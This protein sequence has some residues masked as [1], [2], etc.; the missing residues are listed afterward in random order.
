MTNKKVILG[1]AIFIIAGL[2]IFTF[3]NSLN[4]NGSDNDGNLYNPGTSDNNNTDDDNNEMNNDKDNTSDEDGDKKD[5]DKDDKDS[6]DED[7]ST[8][9]SGTNNGSTS[10][11]GSNQS[12]GSNSGSN[13]NQGGSNSGSNNNQGGSNQGGNSGS[14]N[15]GNKPSGGDNNQGD[16]DDKEDPSLVSKPADFFPSE[17]EQSTIK[18]SRAGTTIVVS[19][20]MKEKTP[21]YNQGIRTGF[22]VDMK[23]VATSAF[24]EEHL[25]NF[26]M[27]GIYGNEYKGASYIEGFQDGKPYLYY[28]I[29]FMSNVEKSIQIDWGDGNLVTYNI[30]FE[31]EQIAHDTESA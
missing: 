11:N 10:G 14:N 22:Y 1:I 30:V 25:Q 2:L 29:E 31:V 4:G 26:R 28:T 6:K 21:L 3:A 27:V 17:I 15:D 16:S 23:I 5:D 20:S 8:N 12:G 24:T 7:D 19:G 13:N 9:G 18:I